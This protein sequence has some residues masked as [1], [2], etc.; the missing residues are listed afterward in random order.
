MEVLPDRCVQIAKRELLFLGPVGLIMY[1]GG[2]L[3]IDRQ[4]SRTAMTVISDVGKRMVREK[5][6]AWGSG[7]AWRRERFCAVGTA[8]KCDSLWQKKTRHRCVSVN[9]IQRSQVRCL[10]C[11]WW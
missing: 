1:L 2:V 10:G 9:R 6:S 7:P 3:F 11:Q 4:R 5:V 8:R